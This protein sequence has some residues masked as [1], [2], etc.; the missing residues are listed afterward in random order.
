MR[1]KLGPQAYMPW[2][3]LTPIHL[4]HELEVHCF[5]LRQ[6]GDSQC[7]PVMTCIASHAAGTVLCY[8]G[9]CLKRIF[10]GESLSVL[11][12]QLSNEIIE[13]WHH[14]LVHVEDLTN[15]LQISHC[16]LQGINGNT[17]RAENTY[18]LKYMMKLLLQLVLYF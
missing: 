7:R 9:I 15:W 12:S 16:L 5:Y 3:S 4:H 10:A 2:V 17:L 18:I 13:L 14:L 8:S 1:T 11:G 6:I